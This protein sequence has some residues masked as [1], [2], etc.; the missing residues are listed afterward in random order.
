MFAS[1]LLVVLVQE[2][3]SFLLHHYP[4]SSTRSHR[5]D[6]HVRPIQ[7]K[8]I[9]LSKLKTI[10]LYGLAGGG[11][12][13]FLE[14]LPIFQ[15]APA[16]DEKVATIA[17]EFVLNLKQENID[18]AISLLD[19]QCTFEDTSFS[20]PT[21]GIEATERRIR[22]LISSTR[23]SFEVV[24]VASTEDAAG[25]QFESTKTA[26]KGIATFTVV[27]DKITQIFWIQESSK[28]GEQNL[29]TLKVA[30]N[31]LELLPKK[32]KTESHTGSS[33][34]IGKTPPE[35]Y[36]AAWNN[37]DMD[38]AID[39]FAEDATY[40]DTAFPEPFQGKERLREHLLK[41]ANAFPSTFSFE[42]DRVIAQT[43][44]KT[45]CIQWHVEN[46]GEALPFT[47]GCS[48]YT[49]GAKDKIVDGI[50][51]VEPSPPKKGN[52]KIALDLIQ[53]QPAR[54][55]PLV[56]WMVYTYVVF[57]SDGI[58]PGSNAL[59]LEQRTWEE[60]R[61]LS[62]NF[63]LVAPLLDLSFSPTV[64]PML[65]GVFNLLL[66]WAAMF[67]GFL[68][69]DRKDKPNIFPMLPAVIGMQFLTSAFLL[70]YLALRSRETRDNVDMSDLSRVARV[71]ESRSL[72]PFLATIGLSS[73]I[74]A[75][76]CR[77]EFGNLQERC[78]SFLSL[79]S[80]D[81]VGSSFLV[82]LV[83]F[84][85]FQ[86]WLVDDDSNRRDFQNDT[87]KDIGKY[88]PFFGMAIYLASRPKLGMIKESNNI[89]R[90][91]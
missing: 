3:E 76:T 85:L 77:P 71:C 46:N 37:R 50:D 60:V 43:G 44:S 27:N 33:R 49:L 29:N 8:P 66:S 39:L 55:V 40:D 14:S 54:L 65:E 32:T 42:V 88:I 7:R 36:F 82:D 13:N 23:D 38:S 30:S 10:Q 35:R 83:L 45:I 70:P 17:T 16:K 31:I 20:E 75:F 53:Q 69:D 28:A 25:V 72:G 47:R 11:F 62:L 58:L 68:S 15:K 4:T 18:W 91:D 86:F 56:T 78:S 19:G 22:L 79:L 63:F 5:I 52:L 81:R 51:F 57:F 80:I 26:R 34:L 48:M 1:F 74:W 9:I 24:R 12:E 59:A 67:A 90:I 89:P 2:S 87:L 6:L 64:H 41:C 84:A 21:E 73:I 61:D